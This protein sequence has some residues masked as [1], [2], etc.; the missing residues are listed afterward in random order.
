MP[1]TRQAQRLAMEQ[2]EEELQEAEAAPVSP[3]QQT[4]ARRR[5]A[6]RPP[7]RKE[8]DCPHLP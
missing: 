8:K 5:E 4:R 1:T 6:K 7:F 2:A 3:N